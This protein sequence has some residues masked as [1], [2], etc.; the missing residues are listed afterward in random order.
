M[1]VDPA[2]A[3]AIFLEAVEKHSPE[4]WEQF[5]D[6]ACAGDAELRH[7]VTILL[8]AHRQA[9]SFLAQAPSLLC[10]PSLNP[11]SA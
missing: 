4:T 8:D 1:N 3:R 10:R 5:L 6:E 9:G 2:Q 11:R 7:Q